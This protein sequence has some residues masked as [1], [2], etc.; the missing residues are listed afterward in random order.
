[1]SP[2]STARSCDVTVLP[3]WEALLADTEQERGRPDV[4]VNAAGVGPGIRLDD[5]TVGDV[6]HTL[7][8][9]FFS[10]VAGTFPV[11]PVTRARARPRR[12]H[13]GQRVLRS[14]RA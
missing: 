12:R 8:A 5:L 7:E 3:A 1:V 9:D 11:L 10:A 4:L 2:A 6:R 14:P 13:R